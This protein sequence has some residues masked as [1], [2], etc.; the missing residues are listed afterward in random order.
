MTVATTIRQDRQSALAATRG[1]LKLWRAAMTQVNELFERVALPRMEHVFAQSEYTRTLLASM[2]PAGRLSI[3]WPGVDTKIFHPGQNL[4]EKYVLSVGRFA[5]PRKN[6]QMLLRAYHLLRQRLSDVPRLVLAGSTGPT[7]CDW[8]LVRELQISEYVTFYE[9]PSTNELAALYRD[10]AIFALSS[11][12]E[13]FG[14]VLTEAMASGVPVV[15]TRCGGPETIILDGKTGYLTPVGDHEALAI[16]MGEVLTQPA[17]RR[18]MVEAGR[19]A[20]EREFSL[21]AS[22][23]AYLKVYDRLLA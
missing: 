5:D 14:V 1:A 19:K 17:L 7:M 18:S 23:Q 10:A 22:G 6:V 9:A 3:A 13:G 12:E 21:T 2:V 16:A 11:N 8:A 15:S 4:G 20:V